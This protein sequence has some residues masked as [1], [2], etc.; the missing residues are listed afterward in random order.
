MFEVTYNLEYNESE[1]ISG[2]NLFYNASIMETTIITSTELVILNY[3]SVS[4]YHR[5]TDISV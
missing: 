4:W 3:S 2:K 1:Y 5:K